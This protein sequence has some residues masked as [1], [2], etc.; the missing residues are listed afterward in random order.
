MFV[1]T[2]LLSRLQ[3]DIV[4]EDG[5]SGHL[6]FLAEVFPLVVEQGTVDSVAAAARYL[7]AMILRS[8]LP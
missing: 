2:R 8:R 1:E 5:W 6:N 4:T 7:Q 3:L